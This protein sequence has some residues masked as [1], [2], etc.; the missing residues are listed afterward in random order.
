MSSSIE[1]TNK[2]FDEIAEGDSASFSRL[3]TDREIK[4]FAAVSGDHN[5]VHLDPEYAAGTQFG[6]CIAHG[7]LT[8]AFIS[9]AIATE[10]PGPGTI[11]LGQTLQFKA[12][13]FLGDTLTVNLEVTGK[14]PKKPWLT[15]HCDVV[16]Q[17][18]KSVASGE[19]NVMAPAKK[20]TVTLIAPPDIQLIEA[21][22]D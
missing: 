15:L 22:G 7:M 16:N 3:V 8:G 2:T 17:E 6:E 11:Y 9:A 13:V 18:G 1:V 12:P 10:L 19:A 5:P 4:L 21:S 14:H 20:E